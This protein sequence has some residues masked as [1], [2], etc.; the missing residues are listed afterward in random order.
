MS[1]AV[2]GVLF[3]NAINVLFLHTQ[4]SSADVGLAVEKFI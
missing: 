1:D 4:A 3:S 2:R